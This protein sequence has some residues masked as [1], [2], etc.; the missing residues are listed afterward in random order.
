M[1]VYVF[2]RVN[3]CVHVYA[4]VLEGRKKVLDPL[5]LELQ[6]V[7]RCLT[8]VL[9]TKLRFSIKAKSTLNHLSHLFNSLQKFS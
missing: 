6:A 3:I 4:A 9:E 7:V 8:C 1:C 2:V 5:V